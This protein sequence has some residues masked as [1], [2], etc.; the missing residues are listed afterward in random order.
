MPPL[1]GVSRCTLVQGEVA[2]GGGEEPT[3]QRPADGKGYSQSKGERSEE[4]DAAL[5]N[6]ADF[7]SNA[8]TDRRDPE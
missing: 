2:A 6:E 1:L 3:N 5:F 4:D 7:S 8:A